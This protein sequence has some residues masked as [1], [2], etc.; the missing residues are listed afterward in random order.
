[1]ADELQGLS[2]VAR[3]A[4]ETAAS[5]EADKEGGSLVADENAG[6]LIGAAPGSA[7]KGN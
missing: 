3:T 6:A 5:P 7:A 1:M 4:G 2:P